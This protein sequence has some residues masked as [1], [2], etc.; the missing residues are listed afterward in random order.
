VGVTQLHDAARD[1]DLSEV[2]RLVSEQPI[3]LRT[4]FM[5]GR[6]ALLVAARNGRLAVVKWLLSNG[7]S[8]EEQ[9]E[10]HNTSL[11]L[12]AMGG[13]FATVKWLVVDCGVSVTARTRNRWTGARGHSETALLA[14]VHE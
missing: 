4:R 3:R 10:V 14:A 8:L 1:G 13:S 6:T 12:A 7:A 11:H 9:D 5:W 2:Q